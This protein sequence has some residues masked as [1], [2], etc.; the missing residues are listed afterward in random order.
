MADLYLSLLVVGVLRGLLSQLLAEI[1]SATEW[2]LRRLL[3]FGRDRRV[4]VV[5]PPFTK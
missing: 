1:D 4:G 3:K 5:S 2:P